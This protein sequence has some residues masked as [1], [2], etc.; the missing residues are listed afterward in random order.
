M[1]AIVTQTVK[2]S[3]QPTHVV[4]R[5][6]DPGPED[7]QWQVGADSRFKG[8]VVII[9]A[10]AALV[11]VSS[12]VIGIFYLGEYAGPSPVWNTFNGVFD[13][14]GAAAREDCPVTNLLPNIVGSRTIIWSGSVVTCTYHGFPY[15]GY[16]GTDCFTRGSSSD[17]YINGTSVPNQGCVLSRAPLN[18]TFTD[19]FTF[20]G[21][22]SSKSVQVYASNKVV[23]NITGTSNWVANHCSF[24]SNNSTKTNGEMKCVLLGV[25]YGT[26]DI[27]RFCNVSGGLQVNGVPVPQGSCILP[28]VDT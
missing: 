9:L 26:S 21:S 23:A 13:S 20:S 6:S 15:I 22:T 27:L 2:S 5:L 11:V 1:Y 17:P 4:V 25:T 14:G 24:S 7:D 10:V 28:R 8:R 3:P 16:V 19:I 18:N 12:V